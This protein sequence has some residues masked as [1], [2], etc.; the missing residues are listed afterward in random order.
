MRVWPGKPH[1]LG[2][3]WDGQ[4]VNFAIFSENATAVELC[5]FDHAEDGRET[6][7]IRL[8]ERDAFVWHAYLPDVRPGQ[9]YGYRA[10]G[11][12]APADGHRF[13]PS[14]LLI[15]RARERL[16]I[17]RF[18]TGQQLIKQHA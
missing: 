8:T 12:W 18:R 3:T 5:L 11:P 10:H 17:E 13:D 6:A 7:R 9:L 1:P 14:Q 2:P 16:L 4:G 15:V